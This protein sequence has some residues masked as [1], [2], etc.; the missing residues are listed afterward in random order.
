[1]IYDGKKKGL[2]IFYFY[3]IFQIKSLKSENV[4]IFQVKNLKSENVLEYTITMIGI[5]GQ[6]KGIFLKW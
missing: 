1:M 5:G 2:G 3:F 6:K 4:L